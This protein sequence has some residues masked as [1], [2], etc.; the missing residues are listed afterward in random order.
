MEDGVQAVMDEM[1]RIQAV[2]KDVR[3]RYPYVK[4]PNVYKQPAWKGRTKENLTLIKDRTWICGSWAEDQSD[5]IEYANASNQYK[6]VT[7]ED[8]V[9]RI[10]TALK[11]MP[12]FGLPNIRIGLLNEGA[13]LRARVVF[14]DAKYEV[15]EKEPVNPMAN[16]YNSYDMSTRLLSQFGAE[17]LVCTNGLVA[18]KVRSSIGQKHRLNID[19]DYIVSEISAGMKQFSDQVGLWQHWAKKE[20]KQPE[21]IEVWDAL[22]F[23]G[24]TNEL[25]EQTG[26]HREELLDY[27]RKLDRKTIRGMLKDGR[28]NAWDAHSIITQFISHEID[29]ENV[30]IDKTKKVAKAF[31]Q[32]VH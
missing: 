22:P 29:S 30:Q 17:E 10:E 1:K 27:P 18:F 13:L 5:E 16:L 31:H 23:G 11:D 15:R 7:H 3:E 4:F 26:R 2:Q 20:L 32:H 12:E 25:G 6:I 28:V 21:W 24:T 14:P 19:T 9:I 8:A